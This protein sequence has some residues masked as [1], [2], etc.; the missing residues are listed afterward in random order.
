ML[1]QILIEVGLALQF[2][3]QLLRLD[4]AIASLLV[5][6]IVGLGTAVDLLRHF[7]LT[8]LIISKIRRRDI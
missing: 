1:I 7:C 2:P 4:K 6:L 5:L 8:R 3:L